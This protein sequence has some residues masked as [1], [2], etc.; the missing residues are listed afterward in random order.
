MARH[1]LSIE[2]STGRAYENSKEEKE[3]FEK[4]ES[5]KGNVSYRKY[6]PKGIYGFLH[7]VETIKGNFG[8]Q[9]SVVLQKGDETFYLN[10]PVFSQSQDIDDF[11]ASFIQVLPNL[12]KDGQ[13]RVFPY[14]IE[15]TDGGKYTN[16][17]VSVKTADVMQEV[18]LDKVEK[19]YNY[20]RKG[21]APIAT[22]IPKLEW[23]EKFGKNTISAVSKEKKVDFLFGKL[24][25][26]CQKLGGNVDGTIRTFESKPKTNEPATTSKPKAD[27][28][29]NSSK[30]YATDKPKPP[31]TD[32]YFDDSLPF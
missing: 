1:Y 28:T 9:I 18:A 7:S 16:R 8:E 30:P 13:Y 14:S 19:A 21:E 6:Y 22:D 3:G 10:I 11:A 4:H 5:T 26:G 2:F 24:I 23:V 15:P 29:K 25:E 32:N 20:T 27:A 31:V 12:K 17:G